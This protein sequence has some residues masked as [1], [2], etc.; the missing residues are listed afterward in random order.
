M[1]VV[2]VVPAPA[3]P[4]TAATPGRHRGRRH[5]HHRS[6][7]DAGEGPP[8]SV[9]PGPSPQ[10]LALTT[11]L[12]AEPGGELAAAAE[13]HAD[14]EESPQSEQLSQRGR[15]EDNAVTARL[16]K[17]KMC[18]FFE[19]GKCAS[20]TC[21]YA[22]SPEELRVMPNLHKT[23]LC[24]TWAQE[25]RCDLLHCAFAHGEAEL[26]VTDGIYKT[27]ICHFYERG[28]CLKGD[29]CNHAHGANDLRQPATTAPG[30][31]SSPAQPPQ[32]QQRLTPVKAAAGIGTPG[33]TSSPVATLGRTPPSPLPLAELLADSGCSPLPRDALR[34]VG[35]PASVSPA[36]SAVALAP[37]AAALLVPPLPL[38]PCEL[39][40]GV[41]TPNQA[42]GFGM[43][44]SPLPACSEVPAPRSAT[45]DC[46][47]DFGGYY[48][49]VGVN[50]QQQWS[51]SCQ[52]GSGVGDASQWPVATATCD[53]GASYFDNLG[54]AAGDP[55]HFGRFV[56]LV[57]EQR[58][59][60]LDTELLAFTSDVRS[61]TAQGQ[62]G[63]PV[64]KQPSPGAPAD[65]S[66]GVPG[67]VAG[68]LQVAQGGEHRIHR[69]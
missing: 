14:P 4:S 15:R 33:G 32:D 29:R 9:A 37:T 6:R 50:G 5:N 65:G 21:S 28:R 43:M 42:D 17:T 39:W 38:A 16:K 25:G 59:A 36:A 51:H 47:G 12:A 49:A 27:Q 40:N 31:A 44:G 48:C 57:L 54:I 34:C 66:G 46:A 53:S 10:L 61:L 63:A 30:A 20:E 26:R 24:K 1:S 11:A 35:F 22:H 62:D 55:Q 2:V 60:S 3:P 7:A 13:E 67:K 8:E 52:G 19:R 41:W 56:P 45:I 23:K 64:W 18:Y 68:C 69:I 58:L